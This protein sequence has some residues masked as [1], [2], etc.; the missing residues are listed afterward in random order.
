[1]EILGS[2]LAILSI[3]LSSLVGVL[4]FAIGVSGIWEWGD[5]PVSQQSTRELQN[6]HA[7]IILAGLLFTPLFI[8]LLT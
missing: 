2:F 3:I 1:M 5:E 8:F 7:C 6:S 4:F